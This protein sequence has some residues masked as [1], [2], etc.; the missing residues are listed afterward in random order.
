MD[1]L[2]DKFQKLIGA[3]KMSEQQ[4]EHIEYVLNIKLSKE[5]REL[6]YKSCYLY[7]T[8]ELYTMLDNESGSVEY[9][10]INLRNKYSEF[11]KKSLLLGEDENCL[12]LME[13]HDGEYEKVYIIAYEDFENYCKG[14]PLEYNPT[15]FPTFADFFEYLLDEEEKLREQAG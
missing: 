3:K 7:F 10:T 1:Y 11:P 12:I 8:Y 6:N 4:I 9:E 5:F 15:I 14:K 13:T 2:I